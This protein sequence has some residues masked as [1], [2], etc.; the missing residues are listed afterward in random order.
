MREVAEAGRIRQFMAAL[1]EAAHDET[2]VYFTGGA[3]AVLKGWRATT[4]D[5]DIE[6]VPDR[7]KRPALS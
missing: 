5:V 6:I 7:R 4:L 3:S 2:R 1:G